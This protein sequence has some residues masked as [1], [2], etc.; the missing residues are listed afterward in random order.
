MK[1][2]DALL[3]VLKDRRL[4]VPIS[5]PPFVFLLGCTEYKKAVDDGASQD[6]LDRLTRL[7]SHPDMQQVWRE[8]ERQERT[9]KTYLHPL[10]RRKRSIPHQDQQPGAFKGTGN[11]PLRA[12]RREPSKLKPRIDSQ[13]YEGAVALIQRCMALARVD[14]RPF[15]GSDV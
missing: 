5:V 2:D 11:I 15:T 7:I 1:P 4:H 10:K 6:V 14:H 13:S 8:L 3:A 9:T 12:E